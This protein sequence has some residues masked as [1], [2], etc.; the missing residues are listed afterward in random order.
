MTRAA[1]VHPLYTILETTH[2][3]AL[4]RTRHQGP[5]LVSR[6]ER[7]RERTQTAQYHNLLQKIYIY[8]HVI[9]FK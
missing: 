3:E 5:G 2:Q 7:T 6:P 8:K 4:S 9:Q 1:D